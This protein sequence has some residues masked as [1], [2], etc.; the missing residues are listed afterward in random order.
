MAKAAFAL[1]VFP[2]QERILRDLAD[3]E[4]VEPAREARQQGIERATP[5]RHLVEL[6]PAIARR[7]ARPGSR[8]ILREVWMPGKCVPE[9]H[10]ERLAGAL[11]L[12]PDHGG[13]ALALRF[14]RRVAAGQ[15]KRMVRDEL[16][17]V[18]QL[19]LRAEGDPGEP[20]TSM[21]GRFA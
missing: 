12:A 3:G 2:T 21:A 15:R 14:H 19:H 18:H 13:A 8:R 7:A 5:L 6:R 16:W 20:A 4:H 11:D 17:L 9:H 10:F 1:R